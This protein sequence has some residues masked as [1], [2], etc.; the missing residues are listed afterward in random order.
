MAPGARSVTAFAWLLAASGIVGAI[1]N[2][3]EDAFHVA[4]AEYLYGV[5][6]FASGIAMIGLALALL[7]SRRWLLAALVAS[8]LVGIVI[9]AGHG[10]P[11]LPL[12]WLFVA[13]VV[14]MASRPP[15]SA[16]G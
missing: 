1:G 12:L 11:I 8:T 16:V 3:L 7:W 14:S 2:A 9:M 13:V 6:F 10:P 5:G 4:N 15:R